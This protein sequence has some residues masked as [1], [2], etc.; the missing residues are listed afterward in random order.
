MMK[1]KHEKD[2]LLFTSLHPA[3]LLIIS[4][5]NW[6]AM[7]RHFVELTITQTISTIDEDRRLGRVSSAHRSGIAC[8]IRTK[9]LDP[10][11]V[12]D[13]IQYINTKE[14]YKHLHYLSNKGVKRL[15]YYHIGTAEHLHVALHKKYS[16]FGIKS[17]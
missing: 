6:Y 16:N 2:M 14:D 9:D 8:D 12:Q 7:S 11:V 5:L 1:F 3:L 17:E 10:F 4:D 13:L 15:A